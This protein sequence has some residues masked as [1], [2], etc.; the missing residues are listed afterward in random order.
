MSR[1]IR[2]SQGVA[3]QLE[4]K[5]QAELSECK[6]TI[7]KLRSEITYFKTLAEQNALELEHA[8]VSIHLEL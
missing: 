2:I 6:A 8:R 1:C 3:A 7:D 5:Y 4:R